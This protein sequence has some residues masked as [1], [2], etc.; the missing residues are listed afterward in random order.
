M[1]RLITDLVGSRINAP[2]DRYQNIDQDSDLA[3]PANGVFNDI[4]DD[5]SRKFCFFRYE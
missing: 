2:E 3:P 4:G 5:I 1:R